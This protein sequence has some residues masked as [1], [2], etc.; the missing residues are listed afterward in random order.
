MSTGRQ[1]LRLMETFRF[2]FYTPIY[3]ALGGGFL[4][5]E[6]LSVKHSTKMTSRG[7]LARKWMEGP[8]T[9]ARRAD[10]VTRSSCALRLRSGHA[11]RTMVNQPI[12][13]A[14]GAGGNQHGGLRL[15]PEP[16]DVDFFATFAPLTKGASGFRPA[17][18]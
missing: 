11:C 4:E 5:A 13:V 8:S 7:S 15:S 10:L 14:C 17:L 9:S 16:R 2:V 6:G 1:L 3:V 18:E 12:F